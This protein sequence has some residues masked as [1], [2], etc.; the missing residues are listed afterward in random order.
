M[1]KVLSSDTVTD[2]SNQAVTPTL[3][4]RTPHA[5]RPGCGLCGVPHP[6]IE[7]WR[8]KMKVL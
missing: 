1:V 5:S 3:Q 4:A 7:G 8:G 6:M 2:T